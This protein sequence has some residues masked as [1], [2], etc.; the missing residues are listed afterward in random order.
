MELLLD[1][2]MAMFFQLKV[3][4]LADNENAVLVFSIGCAIV[5]L[6]AVALDYSL[7]FLRGQSLLKLNHGR[8]TFLFLLAWAFGAFVIGWVGQLA[9]IFLV[10]LAACVFVGFSWPLL[11]TKLLKKA[12]EAESQDE[13]E[14]VAREEN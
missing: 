9:N 7:Y 13:P 5:G 4:T 8:Y 14:Q 12:S 3:A 10:S 6:F 11:F 2:L 1:G